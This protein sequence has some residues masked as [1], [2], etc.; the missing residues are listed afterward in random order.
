MQMALAPRGDTRTFLTHFVVGGLEDDH[1]VVKT[2]PLARQR[3]DHHR[4]F[5]LREMF[6][7]LAFVALRTP[8]MP[9]R[10]L[11]LAENYF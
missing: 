10:V 6:P 4:R 5:S 9:Y 3:R 1:Y 7:R 11:R 8:P 2:L